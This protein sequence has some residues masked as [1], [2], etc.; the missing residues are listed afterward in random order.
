MSGQPVYKISLELMHC[1]FA[2][3]TYMFAQAFDLPYR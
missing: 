2:Y 3:Q 1:V